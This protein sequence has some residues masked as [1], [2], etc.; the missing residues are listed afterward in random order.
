[1]GQESQTGQISSWSR[2]SKDGKDFLII[3]PHLPINKYQD[4]KKDATIQ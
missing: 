1:M 4:Q 3:P 2:H